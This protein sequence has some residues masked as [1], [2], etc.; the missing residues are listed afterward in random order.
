MADQYV[1]TYSQKKRKKFVNYRVISLLILP[2]EVY[3]KCLKK[4]CYEIVKPQLQDAQCRFFPGRSTMDQ[5]FALQQ[6]FEKLWKYA[7]EV[8]TCFVDHKLRAILLDYNVRSQLLAA[9]KASYK[10]SEICV[11]INGI[12]TKL[13]MLVLDYN[14]AVVFILFFHYI[15]GHDRQT[16]FL[17]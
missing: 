14:K 3:S 16:Q 13:L 8:Y 9:I 10:Q 12:K 17:Q 1:D 5:I 4:I 7:K 11:C 2:G 6:V 15:H